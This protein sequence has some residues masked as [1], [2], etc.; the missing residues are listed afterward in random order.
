MDYASDPLFLYICVMQIDEQIE[1]QTEFGQLIGLFILSPINEYQN[2]YTAWFK[3]FPG[4][5]VERDSITE[6]IKQL[7][8]TLNVMLDYN[9]KKELGSAS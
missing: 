9:L 6:C 7:K 2:T 1:V 4:V 8:I 5:I 3:E